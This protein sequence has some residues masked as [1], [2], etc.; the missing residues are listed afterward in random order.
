MKIAIYGAGATGCY[1]GALCILAGQ[2]TT[3]IGRERIQQAIDSAGGITI[4]DYAGQHA[5]VEID[6]FE[7][8]A[9]ARAFDLVLVTLK[10]HQLPAAKAELRLLAQQGAQ[11]VFMQ[12]G[13]ER[14]APILPDLP[15]SACLQGITP[16]N[17]LSQKDAH[18]HRATEGAL[19]FQE[20]TKTLALANA[21]ARIGFVC[22]CY[23]D[24]Q[25]VIY[26]KLLLNLN[27]ALNAITDQ[28]ILEQLENRALRQVLAGAMR[29]WLAVAK[30]EGVALKQFTAVKPSWIPTILSLPNWLFKRLATAM[31]EIDPLARSSMWEDI[32]AGRKTEIEFINGAVADRADALG[33]NA[34]VNRMIA[35][36]VQEK[37]QGQPV[38][39]TRLLNQSRR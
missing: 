26:G 8:Q 38:S 11:L 21:L 14:L 6:T 31:L 2:E 25:P 34:P 12:N 22:E 4:T 23:P 33:L 35:H 20:T 19:V 17:V 9:P 30:A 37:E 32:Q 3:L 27:N 10:C 7:T 16:F 24:M 18:Y 39:V 29:E 5:H 28:P 36:L 13:L 1:L 15:A